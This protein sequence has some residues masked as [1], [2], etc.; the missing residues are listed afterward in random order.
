MIKRLRITDVTR[1]SAPRV[2]VAGYDEHNQC[3]RPILRN[4]P[5]DESDLE[6]PGG[7]IAPFAEVEYDLTPAPGTPPH[8]EDSI[9]N[10][11]GVRWLRWLTESERHALLRATCWPRVDDAF[12][13]PLVNISSHFVRMGSGARS[14]VTIQVRGAPYVQLLTREGKQKARLHFRD[15]TNRLYDL[16]I[17][18]LTWLYFAA[19]QGRFAGA[20]ATTLEPHL[21]RLLNKEVIFVRLGLT[22]EY[23]AGSHQCWLQVNG[24]YTFPDYLDGDTFADYRA[25]LAGVPAA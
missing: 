17:T 1:M 20:D 4:A 12:G 18:D 25:G 9:Y 5:I 19:V 23:P 14:L 3:V 13:A 6:C 15:S 10:P 11:A 8:V 7:L 2:C 16:P 21:N 22:R 24:I